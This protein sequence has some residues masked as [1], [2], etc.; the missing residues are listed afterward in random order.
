[1][2]PALESGA[3]AVPGRVPRLAHHCGHITVVR[4]VLFRLHGHRIATPV[5]VVIEGSGVLGVRSGGLAGICG[6]GCGVYCVGCR[7]LS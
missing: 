4:G 6:L 5:K 3:G 7:F 2:F 1:M